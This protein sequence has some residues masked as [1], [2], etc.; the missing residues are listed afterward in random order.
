MSKDKH[1]RMIIPNHL[2]EDLITE[3]SRKR[4]KKYTGDNVF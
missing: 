1:E 2:E 3:T 4:I